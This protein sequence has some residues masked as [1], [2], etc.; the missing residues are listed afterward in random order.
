MKLKE[1][2]LRNF[3]GIKEFTMKPEGKDVM[4]FGENK[5]GKT[6]VADSLS[7]LLFGKDSLGQSNFEIKTLKDGV[8]VPKLE[9]EVEG[10]FEN[11]GRTIKF[12]RS[13][14]E[15]WVGKRGKNI[16]DKVF[17][18]HSTD[19]LVDDVPLNASS[20]KKAVED[21]GAKEEIFSMLM[22]P[23]VFPDLPWQKKREIL[24]EA[25]GDITDE[26]VIAG[27]PIFAE[28]PAI[29][30]GK[31]VT[32]RKKIIAAARKKINAEMESI[33]ARIDEQDRSQVLVS[34]TKK[35][36]LSEIKRFRD[37]LA[38]KQEAQANIKSGGMAAQIGGQMLDIGVRLNEIEMEVK[39]GNCTVN[40]L[41]EKE[42]GELEAQK[43]RLEYE[44][45]DAEERLEQKKKLSAR[46]GERLAQLGNQFDDLTKQKAVVDLNCPTCGHELDPI[47]IVEAKKKFNENRSICLDEINRDGK[48]Q[49][50]IRLTLNGEIEELQNSLT[51]GKE[52]LAKVSERLAGVVHSLENS[53]KNLPNVADFPEWV[54]LVE[55]RNALA[56]E[57]QNLEKSTE[58]A[59]DALADEV[60]KIQQLVNGAESEQAKN[61]QNEAIEK[62]IEELRGLE[63]MLAREFENTSRVLDLLDSFE[64]EKCLAVE[65]KINSKFALVT[66][67]LFRDQLND[68]IQPVCDIMVDG[69]PFGSLNHAS[70]IQA[71]LDIINT[72][73][74]FYGVRPFV[75][76]DGRESVTHLPDINAQMIS[77][78]VSPDDDSLRV[79]NA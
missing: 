57:L 66:F 74:G 43:R 48:E 30:D 55:K 16:N 37:L 12:K 63:K 75:V 7:W 34:F 61:E 52:V 9:H 18:G 21:L 69:V 5:A 1:L 15:K 27:N 28:L 39:Q 71:G 4:I 44:A 70:R 40:S 62:R 10:V 29:L 32:E 42:R 23:T 54:Q 78:V 36:A 22:S 24:F 46:I 33:P 2:K 14:Y 38:L 35:D 76:I 47:K 19:Y 3:K 20:F 41:L 68:G 17:S 65:E 25:C 67:R 58:A 53:A 6:T 13:F 8:P 77:M 50:A 11:G 79:V 59:L 73:S 51:T 45:K 26:E 72:L 31:T 56:L 60:Q 64:R 49:T